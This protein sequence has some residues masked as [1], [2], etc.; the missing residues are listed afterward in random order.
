MCEGGVIPAGRWLEH[1]RAYLAIARRGEE[2]S[3]VHQVRV[4]SRRLDVWLR[5]GDWHVLRDDLRWLRST[6]ASARDLDVLAARR[7]L[8]A[9]FH[10]WLV[11][12][13]RSEQGGLREALDHERVE[14]IL[15]ALAAMPPVSVARARAAVKKIMAAV[16]DRGSQVDHAS[17]DT[18]ALHRLR[19]ALRRLRFGLEW[20][21]E[22]ADAL[23]KLQDAFGDLNDRAV[24]MRWIEQYPEQDDA[25]AWRAEL[26]EE[27]DRKRIAVVQTWRESEPEVDAMARSWS[28][29]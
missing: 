14:A 5:L 15:D 6:C 13:R 3:G 1:L 2:P 22:P 28:S 16:L 9:D 7:D 23:I 4:A 10:D 21:G 20:V 24:L 25:A 18:E 27:L 11:Q 12:R 19:R 17:A 29:S 26:H 8:P